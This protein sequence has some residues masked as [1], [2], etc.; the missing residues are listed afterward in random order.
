MLRF[1]DPAARG[2]SGELVLFDF[3]LPDCLI[4]MAAF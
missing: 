4:G 3:W 2:G 1:L